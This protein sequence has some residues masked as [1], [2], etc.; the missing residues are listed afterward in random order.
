MA[1]PMADP[2][3]PTQVITS[4]VTMAHPASAE[5]VVEEPAPAATQAPAPAEVPQATEGEQPAGD[6]PATGIDGEETIWE[7]RYSLKNFL[8]RFLLT[9]LLVIGW[10]A[11]AVATWGTSQPSVAPAITVILGILLG[12]GLVV[13]LRRVILARFGHHYHLTNRRLFVATGV[14]NRRRDQMELLKVDDVYIKQSLLQRWLGL[15]TVV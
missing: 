5:P 2:N 3:T 6:R 7:A 12:L 1:D 14:L 13:L 8:F 15:G 10:L 9:G 11:L 4:E